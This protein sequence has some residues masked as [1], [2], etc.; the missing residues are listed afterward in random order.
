MAV[1]SSGQL[2]LYGD[3]GTELGVAQ[4]N[5]SLGGMSDT[6]GFAAPD[7]MSDFYGYSALPSPI[8]WYKLDGNAND[9]SGNGYNGTAVN[10]SYV[11]GKF[12]QAGSFNGSSSYV[13]LGALKSFFY[14]NGNNQNCSVS[15]WFKSSN[16]VQS[17]VMFIDFNWRFKFAIECQ[18]SG[19]LMTLTRTNT[20]DFS[21]ITSGTYDDNNWHNVVVTMDATTNIRRTYIDSTLLDSTTVN[22]AFSQNNANDQTTLGAIIGFNTVV[23]HFPGLIDQV[24]V[25]DFPLSASEVTSLYNE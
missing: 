15:L 25:Y 3:I 21:F 13:N 5:V 10:L 1:P 7:A 14:N 20:G 23:S 12:G 24:R 22:G 18:G 2:D 9:S 8:A 19:Q 6:A 17:K 16:F 11:T 4:S